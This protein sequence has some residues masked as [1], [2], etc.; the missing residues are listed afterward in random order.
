MKTFTHASI[1]ER[2]GRTLGR[3][4]IAYRR[5]EA[6]VLR[7]M[8]EKGMSSGSANVVLWA[9]KLI[10]L[11][12]LLYAAFWVALLAI[13][14]VAAAWLAQRVDDEHEHGEWRNGL[15]GYGYY[16]HGLRTDYGRLFEDDQS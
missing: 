1:A 10:V 12:V 9:V 16:E 11:G 14:V 15:E 7:W 13:F 5:H 3:A 6:R 8:V 2:M 4:W